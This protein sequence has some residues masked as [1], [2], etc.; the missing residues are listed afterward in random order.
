MLDFK[1]VYIEYFVKS[2]CLYNERCGDHN[3]VQNIDGT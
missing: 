1:D 2:K 3:N